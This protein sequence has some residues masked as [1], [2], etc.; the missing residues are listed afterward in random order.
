MK[1]EKI[2]HEMLNDEELI[3]SPAAVENLV[4]KN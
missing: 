3:K 2:L 1:D 4:L